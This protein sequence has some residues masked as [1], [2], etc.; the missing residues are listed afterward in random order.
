[1]SK[2]ILATDFSP[3]AQHAAIYAAH[4]ADN[5]QMELLLFHT[6][7]IPFAYTDSAVPLLNIE[8]SREISETS[9]AFEIE[10]IRS[11]KPSLSVTSKLKPGG[12]I[13]SL[14]EE[15]QENPPALIL[16]GSSGSEIDSVLWG[17]MAVKALRC[18]RVPVLTIPVKAT[19]HP[20]QKIGFAADY[21]SFSEDTPFKEILEWCAIMKADLSVVHIDSSETEKM[22]PPEILKS[23]LREKNPTYHSVNNDRIEEGVKSF[24]EQNEIDWL[25]LI[26]QE[27]GFWRSLFHK[28]KTKMLAQVSHIPILALHQDK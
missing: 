25:L 18:F 9:M 21:R 17:S 26:P 15:I 7:I 2:I 10:R 8:E 19:W 4:L 1:M 16:L 28:S 3:V 6:F 23:A 20:I 5:L 11:L 22:E 24:I 27:F 14:K 13:E 12:F